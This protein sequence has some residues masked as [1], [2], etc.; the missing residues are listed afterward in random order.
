MTPLLLRSTTQGRALR[1]GK[2]RADQAQA[3]LSQCAKKRV[4]FRILTKLHHADATETEIIVATM[5]TGVE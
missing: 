2:Y 1:H 5:R 4:S 3:Y